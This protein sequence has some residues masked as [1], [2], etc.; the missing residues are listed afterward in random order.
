MCGRQAGLASGD[1]DGDG[2]AGRF[3][4]RYG[5]LFQK[6]VV[7]VAGRLARDGHLEADA[8]HGAF[9][10]CR[11]SVGQRR[12][13]PHAVRRSGVP[14]EDPEQVA[15]AYEALLVRYLGTRT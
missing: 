2:S 8:L 13:D 7:D 5:P 15:A 1:A 6:C 3:A 14:I 4:S 12:F 9:R 10:I 11:K